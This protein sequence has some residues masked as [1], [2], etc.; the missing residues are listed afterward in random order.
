M[1]YA[2]TYLRALKTDCAV[3]GRAEEPQDDLEPSAAITAYCSAYPFDSL[4]FVLHRAG[5]CKTLIYL[6]RLSL[7]N[8]NA[9]IQNVVQGDE[10]L[11]SS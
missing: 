10:V 1:E 5:T 8:V 11:P 7:F 6:V 3:I 4:L 9:E 2:S